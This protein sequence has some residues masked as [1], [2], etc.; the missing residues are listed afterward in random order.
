MHFTVIWP[1]EKRYIKVL[2][3]YHLRTKSI[4]LEEHGVNLLKQF[5]KI[6]ISWNGTEPLKIRIKLLNL[7]SAF[8]KRCVCVCVCVCV[9]LTV[10]CKEMKA[11]NQTYLSRTWYGSTTSSSFPSTHTEKRA[12]GN[13]LCIKSLGIWNKNSFYSEQKI[14]QSTTHSTSVFPVN[15]NWNINQIYS[16]L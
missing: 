15:P 13:N 5:K 1:L 14:N 8:V 9:L 6:K 7:Q 4:I 3:W 16:I 10:N 2:P 11:W 12:L